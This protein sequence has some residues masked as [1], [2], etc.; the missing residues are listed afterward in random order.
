MDMSIAEVI[1]PNHH[2][3][4]IPIAGDTGVMDPEGITGTQ[5]VGSQCVR[6]DNIMDVVDITTDIKRVIIMDM[7]TVVKVDTAKEIQENT[8][9]DKLKMENG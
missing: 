5:A 4:G 3:K 2:V 9:A 6:I 8:M 1:G 7:A